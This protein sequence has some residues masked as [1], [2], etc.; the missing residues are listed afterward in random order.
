MGLVEYLPNPVRTRIKKELL[1]RYFGN[2]VDYAVNIEGDRRIRI[3]R[4]AAK[5]PFDEVLRASYGQAWVSRLHGLRFDDGNF[6][7]IRAQAIRAL[8]DPVKSPC[9]Y[10]SGIQAEAQGI[11]REIIKHDYRRA[12]TDVRSAI[13]DAPCLLSQEVIHAIRSAIGSDFFMDGVY[14]KRNFHVEPEIRSK[15]DLLSDRWHFDHQYPDGFSLFVNLGD[16]GPE[17]GPTKWINRPDS[18]RMLRSGYDAD[19]RVN[20]QSGGLPD[21]TIEACES[22]D[23][24]VGPAGS[25]ALMHTS[26]CLHASGVP[27]SPDSHRD[28]LVFTFRPSTRLSVAWPEL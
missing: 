20:S 9:C 21:G 13:P 3:A 16:F 27:A 17:H 28:T 10:N 26:Y 22:F 5:G 18:L 11:P 23:S 8:D 6:A 14:L 19:N 1:K 24:L 15:Y 4:R 12:T 2:S 7:R 25:M